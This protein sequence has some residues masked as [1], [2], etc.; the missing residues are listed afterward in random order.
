MKNQSGF[1]L[2][3]L[4]VVIVILG[5]LSAVAVP[6]FISIRSDAQQSAM[7]ELKGA[8]ESASTLVNAKAIVEGLGNLQDAELSSG[9]KIHWGYPSNTQT[10]IRL[11]LDFTEGA[12]WELTGSSP[13]IFTF[14]SD[15]EGMLADAIKADD[16]L[17]K[18]TYKQANKG[19]RPVISIS[20]CAD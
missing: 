17:C 7:D 20:G 18:L 14:L 10:N 6:K 8:L 3:E 5:I 9:I 1:T 4:V 2:I 12:D 11:V 13:I 19:Q 15:T 16:T